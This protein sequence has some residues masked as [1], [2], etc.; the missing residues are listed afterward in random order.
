MR[1]VIFVTLATL[2]GCASS[3]ERVQAVRAA[4]P[5]WY[6]DRKTE[7]R[8]EDYPKLTE[9]PV[10]T[11]QT[12]PGQQLSLRQEEVER[13]LAAFDADPRSEGV[14]E[15]PEEILAWA[16]GVRVA[17]ERAIPAAEFLSD[18][19]VAALKARFSRPRG[20]L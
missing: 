14:T 9:I 18:D 4:A 15:T 19:E 16:R 3:L 13:V 20:R 10:I 6:E 1:T 7:L 5:S 2:A 8:G 11:D 17:V 12:R